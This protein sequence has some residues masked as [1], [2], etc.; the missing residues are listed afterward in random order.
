MSGLPARGHCSSWKTSQVLFAITASFLKKA[1]PHVQ[2]LSSPKIYRVSQPDQVQQWASWRHSIVCI[3]P[4]HS[5]ERV[6]GLFCWEASPHI[7][8]EKNHQ[9]NPKT[10]TWQTDLNRKEP[11][12]FFLFFRLKSGTYGTSSC[13]RACTRLTLN[14]LLSQSQ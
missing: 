9:K 6:V 13:W 7:I 14:T 3:N 8:T 1:T 5:T 12:R 2:T 10:L 4:G 11:K